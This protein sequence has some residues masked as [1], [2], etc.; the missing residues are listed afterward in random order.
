M[1]KESEDFWTCLSKEQK[2]MIVIMKNLSYGYGDSIPYNEFTPKVVDNLKCDPSS[3]PGYVKGL[4]STGLTKSDAQH[5][6]S[7]EERSLWITEKGQ[8]FI[9]QNQKMIDDW[10]SR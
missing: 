2:M 7:S 1:T 8:R 10:A 4:N 9:F 3:I 6:S 5:L